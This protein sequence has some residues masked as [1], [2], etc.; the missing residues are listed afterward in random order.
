MTQDLQILINNTINE[1]IDKRDEYMREHE[2][3]RIEV[4]VYGALENANGSYY[5]IEPYPLTSNEESEI[6]YLI[7]MCESLEKEGF[8]TIKLLL[9]ARAIKDGI[10]VKEVL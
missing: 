6:L 9:D 8:T 10:V 2:D 3:E 5:E 7:T 1:L 4:Q